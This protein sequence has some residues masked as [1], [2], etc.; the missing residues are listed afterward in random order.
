MLPPRYSPGGDGRP[1]LKPGLRA[2]TLCSTGESFKVFAYH[3][4]SSTYY[5]GWLRR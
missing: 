5:T 3:V 4:A 1:G 2:C